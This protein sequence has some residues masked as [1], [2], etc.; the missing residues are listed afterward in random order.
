VRVRAALFGTLLFVSSPLAAQDTRL[1]TPRE[2]IEEAADAAPH[3]VAGVF[4]LEVHATGE[5][6]GRIFL[7]SEEDYRD[8]RNLTIEIPPNV[9][10]N[11][12]AKYGF[13]PADFFKGKHVHVKGLA[14]R[15]KIWFFCDGKKSDKY[16]YQ[17]HVS[18]T[19]TDNIEVIQ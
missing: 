6:N 19:E 15:V 11:L 5:E 2:A 12:E 9:A 14:E 13:A 1:T 17:T 8:Q 3:L 4:D 18:L 7:N 10:A 16:Y